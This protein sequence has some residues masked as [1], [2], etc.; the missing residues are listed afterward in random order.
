MDENQ[1]KGM[2]PDEFSGRLLRA[3]SQGKEEVYIV[4][5]GTYGNHLKRFFP[6][7]LSRILRNR[8]EA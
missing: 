6:G 1:Q 2:A 7:L 4:G 5:S 8:E 3:V